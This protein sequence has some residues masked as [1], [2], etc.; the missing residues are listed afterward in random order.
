[1]GYQSFKELK[2]WQEAKALAVD[3][4]KL[5]THGKFLKDFGLKE[6]LQRASVSIASNIAEGYERNSDKDFVR[7]IMFAKGSIAEL[8]TQLEIAKEIGYI[9]ETI[10]D[11]LESRCNKIG[12]MLTKL[13][14][15]RR[16]THE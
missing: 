7:F 6:Q 4:Y 3:I 11:E 14:H 2:V 5:T 13:I 9:E 10:S 8:R 12:A 16:T 1:M 15:S